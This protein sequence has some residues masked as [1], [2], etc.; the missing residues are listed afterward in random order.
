M[1]YPNYDESF[2]N[3]DINNYGQYQ[4]N[5]GTT[6]M[7]NFMNSQ[8][9]ENG[10]NNGLNNDLNSNNFS[11]GNIN[12]PLNRNSNSNFNNN[13]NEKEYS[14]NINNNNYNNNFINNQNNN[15]NNNNNYQNSIYFN[16]NDPMLYKNS[17]TIRL[18]IYNKW[19]DEG[20]SGYNYDKLKE[21]IENVLNELNKIENKIKEN[22]NNT[23]K[24]ILIKI[25]SDMDQTC[26]RYE[27]LI[28][29]KK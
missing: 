3:R 5:N 26:L 29:E 19:I 20:K 10:V 18:N 1:F 14:N 13:Y 25:K 21:G 6:P 24:D 28:K 11:A 4:N 16:S 9:N 27:N 15:F 8:K 17:W 23:I 7:G 12:T 22:N 2:N